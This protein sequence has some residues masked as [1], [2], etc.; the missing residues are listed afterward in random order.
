MKLL[1]VLAPKLSGFLA[2]NHLVDFFPMEPMKFLGDVT[3]E[4]IAR[5]KAKQD[6]RD[7]FIQSIIEREEDKTESKSESNGKDVKE[8]KDDEKTNSW[9]GKLKNTLT[10]SEILAQAIL[11]LAAGY[12]TTATTLEFISYNLATHQDIQDILIDE[13]DQVLDKHVIL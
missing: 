12:E 7:D 9:N 1:S 4:I 10:N 6:V 8:K 11:F 13:I 2:R 3:N 5:R